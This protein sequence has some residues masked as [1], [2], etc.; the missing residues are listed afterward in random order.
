MKDLEECGTEAHPTTSYNPQENGSAYQM[1][2]TI[3]NSIRTF[4]TRA[5]APRSFL[6]EACTV[7]ATCASE[8]LVQGNGDA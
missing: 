7:F 8:G 1:N 6:E 3:E 4:L 5:G 2:F